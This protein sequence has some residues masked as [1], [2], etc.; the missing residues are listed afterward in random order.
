LG[1]C[2][3]PST[4]HSLACRCYPA[5][6]AAGLAPFLEARRFSR[7]ASFA[8]AYLMWACGLS[9]AA[10]YAYARALSRAPFIPFPGAFPASF[11]RPRGK[12]GAGGP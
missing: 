7:S 4:R 11:S 12:E 8:I 5:R 10:A 9:F 2:V 1:V 3:W 6:A